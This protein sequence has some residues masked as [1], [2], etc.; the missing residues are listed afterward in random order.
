MRKVY[1]VAVVEGGGASTSLS[2]IK[3]NLTIKH[4]DVTKSRNIGC[5]ISLVTCTQEYELGEYRLGTVACVRSRQ[6]SLQT[7]QVSLPKRQ[8]SL[9]YAREFGTKSGSATTLAWMRSVGMMTSREA[10]EPK[11]NDGFG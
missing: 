7:R 1:H 6:V 8:V 11:E 3:D 4:I 9:I 2:S 10:R 5:D